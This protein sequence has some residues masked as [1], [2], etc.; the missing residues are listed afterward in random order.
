MKEKK[1]VL[2][3]IFWW[4][5]FCLIVFIVFLYPLIFCRIPV[6]AEEKEDLRLYSQ[7]AILID[8]DSGRILYG[9][10]EKQ[11]RPMASTTKIMTCILALEQGKMEDVVTVSS[12]AAS[13][14]KV[15]MGVKKG[16]QYLLKDL[17]YGLM[18]ESYNDAAVMIAE[19]IGGT[20]EGFAR[21]MN[22]KADELG[23][24]DTWFITPNG[25]DAKEVDE[26]GKERIHSTTAEDLAKIL[27]YCIQKSPKAEEF[28]KITQTQDRTFYDIE[29]KHQ[30]QCRNHN[31]FLS[32]MDGALTG[33]TG[34]TGGAGYSYVGA[35]KK[36]GK[37]FVIA[38][39][40]CGWPPYKTRK[41]SDARTLF[42]YGMKNYEKTDLHEYLGKT[43]RIPVTVEGGICWGER[44]NSFVL[45]GESQLGE[46]GPS[47]FVYALLKKG[48]KAEKKVILP[49][50]LT[51]PVKE[52]EKI[53]KVQY[54]IEG[55]LIGEL[56]LY[57]DRSVGKMYAFTALKHVLA[58]WIRFPDISVEQIRSLYER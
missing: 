14:P 7:S 12:Y 29:N 53:G 38:L 28:L 3:R 52:G 2:N 15:H 25:L 22:A 37:L 35:L 8:G 18:L 32:M 54:Y 48:E 27:V 10:N 4:K 13:Q 23:C 17:L 34:F 44:E 40:G 11:I 19:Q 31:A 20:R 49:E 46:N 51:A 36:D 26:T 39:L 21:L 47:A 5:R 55:R 56:S 16:E 43:E 30:I 1:Q 24:K 42:S 6:F 57:S 45:A 9:K 50:K 58:K 33:K 41:W